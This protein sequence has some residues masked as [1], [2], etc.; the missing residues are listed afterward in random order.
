MTSFNLLFC[1][2]ARKH[3]LALKDR[4]WQEVLLHSLPGSHGVVDRLRNHG[5]KARSI[6]IIFLLS[7]M[8]L[9]EPF[10][11]DPADLKFDHRT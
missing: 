1:L 8:T 4:K 9:L 5:F 10:F 11:Q 7:Y 2:S 6:Q 3:E